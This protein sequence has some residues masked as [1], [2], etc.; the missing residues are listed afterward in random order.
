M[1]SEKETELLEQA[2]KLFMRYGIKS[3]TMSDIAR[4]LKISKKTLYKYVTD[5]NDLVSKTIAI[6]LDQQE[7]EFEEISKEVEDPIEEL[8]QIS[9]LAEKHLKAIHPSVIFD[10]QKFHPDAWTQFEC[11]K[12]THI[13]LSVMENLECGK[14]NGV[15]REDMESAII[16][17]LFIARFDILFNQDI[18]PSEE[19]DLAQVNKEMM[20]YHLNA[21]LSKKGRKQLEGYNF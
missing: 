20:S 9:Q 19:F 16:A 2:G 5:K 3:L 13:Y 18:F 21:I 4:E 1:K 14:K 12:D 11:H 7:C 8:I 17:K 15:Y 6:V 10:I